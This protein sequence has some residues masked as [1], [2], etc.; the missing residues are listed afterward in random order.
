MGWPAGTGILFQTHPL[1]Y[2]LFAVM[3]MVA[4]CAMPDISHSSPTMT[5]GIA[6][7]CRLHSFLA[8]KM[9]LGIVWF[10]SSQVG[11]KFVRAYLAEPMCRIA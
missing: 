11:E 4:A 1:K 9:V 2:W 5:E 10:I 8:K 7:R 3:G 6:R